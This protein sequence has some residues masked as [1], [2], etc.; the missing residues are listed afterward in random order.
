MRK[1]AIQA[2]RK[3][4]LRDRTRSGSRKMTINTHDDAGQPLSPPTSQTDGAHD[5]DADTNNYNGPQHSSGNSGED[6]EAQETSD[7]RNADGQIIAEDLPS[8]PT[9]TGH[10][11][12]PSPN[13]DNINGGYTERDN[14]V[15]GHNTENAE[16]YYEDSTVNNGVILIN[17][18]NNQDVWKIFFAGGGVAT[19]AFY[20]GHTTAAAQTPSILTNN[21][22]AA[23]YYSQCSYGQ[24]PSLVMSFVVLP[25]VMTNLFSLARQRL[26]AIM[27][28]A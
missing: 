24:A 2:L 11:D 9:N 26:V 13:I 7:G 21:T 16:N 18:N 27:A 8:N 15:I 3:L 6:A 1:T 28:R 4:G 20:A 19:T 23:I 14:R 12:G 10:F 25:V 5:Y 22:I 17:N